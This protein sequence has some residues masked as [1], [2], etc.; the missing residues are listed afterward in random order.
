MENVL[1]TVIHWTP[2]EAEGCRRN[3]L[4]VDHCDDFKGAHRKGGGRNVKKELSSALLTLMFFLN[5]IKSATINPKIFVN[6]RWVVFLV[7]VVQKAAI[8]ETVF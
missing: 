4:L 8:L 3:Q 1:R 7:K 5:G 6:S 2:L